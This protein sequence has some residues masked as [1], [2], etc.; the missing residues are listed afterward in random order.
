MYLHRRFYYREQIESIKKDSE[1]VEFCKEIFPYLKNMIH[2]MMPKMQ[3]TTINTTNNN[4]SFYMFVNKRETKKQ[5]NTILDWPHI[6]L[7]CVA[8]YFLRYHNQPVIAAP[9]NNNH[10][11]GDKVR[12]HFNSNIL[13]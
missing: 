6:M 11:N 5:T 12:F 13:S 4:Y 3:P 2:E 1:K 9:T 7:G 8:I 10:Q